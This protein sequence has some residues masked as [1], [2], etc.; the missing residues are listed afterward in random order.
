MIYISRSIYGNWMNQKFGRFMRALPFAILINCILIAFTGTAPGSDAEAVTALCLPQSNVSFVDNIYDFTIADD[1]PDAPTGYDNHLYDGDYESILNPISSV[2]ARDFV[3]LTAGT[4]KVTSDSDQNSVCTFGFTSTSTYEGATVGNAL[5][6]ENDEIVQVKII[7]YMKSGYFKGGNLSYCTD[8][9]SDVY[10]TDTP[11]DQGTWYTSDQIQTVDINWD[12]TSSTESFGNV[13]R[14]G[15]RFEW[16]LLEYDTVTGESTGRPFNVSELTSYYA[17]RVLLQFNNSEISPT[18]TGFDGFQFFDY[19]GVEYLYYPS[20]NEL[21]EFDNPYLD[22][23]EMITALMYLIIIFVPAIA[24][25][26]FVPKIGF[27]VGMSI[28]LVVFM[29]LYT[30]F[31]YVSLIGLISVALLFYKSEDE[32]V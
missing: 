1:D 5:P 17:F 19:I 21:T 32:F 31:L 7:F 12:D 3:S 20:S 29:L 8:Y 30:S 14:T 24:L 22:L 28:M 26:Y 9:P 25:N 23:E 15:Q 13:N 11:M 16:T 18:T 6:Q 27:A 4:Y 10:D 2:E